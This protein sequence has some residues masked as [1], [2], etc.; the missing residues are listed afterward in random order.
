MKTV[1]ITGA[2][3]GIGAELVKKFSAEGWKVLATDRTP[4]APGGLTLDVTD[5]ASVQALRKTVGVPDVIINNAGIGLLGPAV[6]CPDEW[7]ARQFDVNVRGVARMVRAFAPGMCERG[8]GRIINVSSLIGV[9]SMPWFGSYA[10]S[11]HALE[12]LS[13]SMRIELAPFGV[14]LSLVEPSIV[15]TGFVDHAVRALEQSRPGS[16]WS[17]ALEQTIATKDRF[18]AVTVKPEQVAEAV[19]RAATARVPRAR[20]RVGWLASVL[21]RG[22]ALLPTFLNDAILRFLGGFTR[23]TRSPAVALLPRS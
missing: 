22:S 18:D 5:E 16:L 13:D 10:A 1:L 11:K 12:A 23:L 3:G 19:F 15:S 6:E 7:L 4:R 21:I 9:F 17:G 14:R 2:S 20:Y 8:H